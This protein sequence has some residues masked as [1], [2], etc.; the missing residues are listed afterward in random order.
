MKTPVLFARSIRILTVAVITIQISFGFS[1]LSLMPSHAYGM[2]GGDA[3]DSGGIDDVN[4][5]LNSPFVAADSGLSKITTS[6]GI[7]S[8]VDPKVE[9]FL[10][11]LEANRLDRQPIDK[12]DIFHLT[13]Q[14]VEIFKRGKDSARYD[15]GQRQIEIPYVAFTSLKISYDKE[16]KVLAF[17]AYRGADSQGNN[18]FLAA[19]HTIR[20]V[21]VVASA[22][23]AELF[24]FVDKDMRLHAIDLGL[25]AT[26]VFRAPIPIFQNLWEPVHV[27]GKLNLIPG[28]Q[29]LKA[30]FLTRGTEPFNLRLAQVVP[31]DPTGRP[32]LTAGDFYVSF[33]VP[34][35]TERYAYGIFSRDTTYMLMI[36]GYKVLQ[37]QAALLSTDH[38]IQ[39]QVEKLVDGLQN[40]LDKQT[41]NLMNE[42]VSP[43]ARHILSSLNPDALKNL[44]TRQTAVADLKSKAF[45]TFTSSEWQDT[46]REVATNIKK[47]PEANDTKAAEEGWFRYINKINA[48]SIDASKKDADAT[49]QSRLQKIRAAVISGKNLKTVG[50]AMTMALTGAAFALPYAYDSIESIREIQ[51]V[52]WV[53]ENYFPA[54][55]KD[56]VYRTPLML[57]IISLAAIWPEAVAFSALVG[58]TFNQMAEKMKAQTSRKAIY[59]KDLAKNWG[60]LNNWQRINSF[61]LRFYGWLILPYWRVLIEHVGRQPTFFSALNSDLNPLKKILASSEVGQ[62]L[63]ITEDQR[64]G[65]IRVFGSD[66]PAEA[67]QS[68]KVQAELVSQN[69]K[70]DALALLISATLIAEKYKMDPATILT[71]REST[72]TMSVDKIAGVLDSP[73]KRQEWELVS[74][75]LIKQMSEMK[76][77]S[78]VVDKHLDELI[79]RY[80]EVGKG[81]AQKLDS[82]PEI[83]KRLLRRRLAFSSFMQNKVK[84]LANIGT[85]DSEFLRRI[86]TNEF[87][88]EQV[89]KEFTIDHMMV[90]GIIALYGERADLSNPH[91]LAADPKGFLWTSAAHWYDI[92]LNTLAHFFIS[93]A[94]MA[95][96]LQKVKPQ[97]AA[98][99][100]P[101]ED[102][103]YESRGREQPLWSATKEWMQVFNPIKSDLGGLVIR[104]LQKSFTTVTAGITLMLVMRVGILNFSVGSAFSAWAFNFIAAQWFFG[105]I[106]DPV[107]R[108]NQM[109]EERLEEASE[110]LKEARRQISRGDLELGREQLRALYAKYNPNI[111]KVADITQLPQDELL[112][113][114]VDHPPIFTAPNKWMSWIT[115]WGA[116]IGSTVLA[117]PLSVILTDPHLLHM[118][119]TWYKWISISALAYLGSYLLSA[120][121]ATKYRDFY[122]SL[123]AKWKARGNRERPSPTRIMDL[124]ARGQQEGANFLGGMDV[125]LDVLRSQGLAGRSCEALFQ[126]AP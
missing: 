47:T 55:L 14:T 92:F 52:S 51:V 31:Q 86:Y 76:S 20:N 81:I 62:K 102:Y 48:A 108:G 109:E 65:L 13:G 41:L 88:S 110:R 91:H 44:A 85:Q 42:K 26:Q 53:Y 77:K 120:K 38:K 96:T 3:G 67:R 113:L 27:T 83:A 1:A 70:L 30:G 78:I 95:L 11:D 111:L 54:V 49:P 57:S 16:S 29:S 8:N 40:E 37:W 28:P 23:D 71:M 125:M 122:S 84:A 43:A 119:E 117:I 101:I 74:E 60:G 9:E 114:S 121:Y 73:E 4:L 33:E 69:Q 34:T 107:Q 105:W 118:P 12:A 22:Q 90:V 112:R 24:Q 59:I 66:R 6:G 126:P 50:I 116:A 89:R 94:R 17:E 80:Y 100:A 7:P 2:E 72:E 18:G 79:A 25:V 87:I 5:R 10:Q 75:M 32:R 97:V 21:D 56:A 104:R 15:L 98:N 124:E 58:K 46:A 123:V 68:M 63:G 19:R 35:S 39:A 82:S 99:Y 93:G 61:G 115:T 64:V 103:R 36:R 106:W 45:D